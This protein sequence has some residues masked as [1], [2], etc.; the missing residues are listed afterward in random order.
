[1]RA[2]NPDE[3][4]AVRERAYFIWEREGQ[5]DDRAHEHWMLAIAEHAPADD[6]LLSEQEAILDG[7]PADYPA[8]L[9]K[10]AHGG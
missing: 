6:G 1:M 3:E 2:L 8:V 9:T 10:D 5:P 4:R 7:R